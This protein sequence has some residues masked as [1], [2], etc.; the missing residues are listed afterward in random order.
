MAVWIQLP[1]RSYM[2]TFWAVLA[3]SKSGFSGCQAIEQQLSYSSVKVKHAESITVS[4]VKFWI[5]TKLVEW[6]GVGCVPDQQ[7]AQVARFLERSS[8]LEG[9]KGQK[10]A[11]D[12]V[13]RKEIL[14][15][16]FC[17]RKGSIGWP[18]SFVR[19]PSPV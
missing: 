5:L 13:R 6:F 14:R 11:A 2:A 8:Q 17:L 1:L 4:L 12:C 15:S 18:S 9:Q 16:S 7:T 19:F 3:K 10:I